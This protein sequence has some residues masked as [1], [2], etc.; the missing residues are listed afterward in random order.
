[1]KFN[2]L[3]P[4]IIQRVF[5]AVLLFFGCNKIFSFL[6]IPEHVGFAEN[7]FQTIN[8]SGYIMPII[9]M[10]QIFAGVAFLTNRYVALGLV[11]LFPITLNIFLFHALHAVSAIVPATIFMAWN[12]ML[13]FSRFDK[14]RPLLTAK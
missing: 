6:P 5:G 14:Y 2:I 1:M 8:S 10:V 13:I 3:I 4:A 11:V 12:T 9:A 7:F